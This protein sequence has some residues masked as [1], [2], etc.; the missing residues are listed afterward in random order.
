MPSM[1]TTTS[2]V[3]GDVCLARIPF[4]SGEADKVRPVV[5]LWLDGLDC[6]V[7]AVTTA[8]PRGPRDLLLEDW[9]SAGLVRPSTCRLGRLN[10][11]ELKLLTRRIGR[12]TDAD[13]RAVLRLWRR[14]I[15]PAWHPGTT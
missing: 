9:E 5:V 7:C 1:T 15:R 3:P 12:L 11:M 6:V 2:I 14:H 13:A 10:T 4:T 8:R